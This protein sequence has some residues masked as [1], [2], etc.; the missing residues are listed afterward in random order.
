MN[1]FITDYGKNLLDEVVSLGLGDYWCKF[2]GNLEMDKESYY[3]KKAQVKTFLNN[4]K[5]YKV[6]FYNDDEM[7]EE[8]DCSIVLL[9]DAEAYE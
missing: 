4:H 6:S 5:E 9:Y 8:K 3:T 1:E 2:T 7:V